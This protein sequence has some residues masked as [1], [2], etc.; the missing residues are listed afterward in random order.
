MIGFSL[1][2]QH[3]E[4]MFLGLVGYAGMLV[5]LVAAGVSALR[6]RSLPKG[7]QLAYLVVTVVAVLVAFVPYQIWASLG[8]VTVKRWTQSKQARLTR[9]CSGLRT[10]ALLGCS[11]LTRRPLRIKAFSMTGPSSLL[12]P[13]ALP[14]IIRQHAGQDAPQFVWLNE[15]G[16]VTFRLGNRF[17][18]WNP[19]GSGLDL[20]AERVRLAW[21]IQWHPVPRILDW[22]QD[23]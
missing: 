3:P 19:H 2:H 10:L 15:R 18:K 14:G 1:A 9:A 5:W 6:R 22:G 16:G 23:D 4:I 7:V 13:P 17:V 12:M 21:A 20:E 8:G 11:L